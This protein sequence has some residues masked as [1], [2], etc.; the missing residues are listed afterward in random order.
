MKTI[1]IVIAAKAAV[2]AVTG[3]KAEVMSRCEKQGDFWAITAEIVETKARIADN[4]MMASYVL[5][6]DSTAD[7]VSYE[8]TRRYVRARGGALDAA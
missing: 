3:I 7:L 1:D 6:L 4:D 2:E 8:R 5:T